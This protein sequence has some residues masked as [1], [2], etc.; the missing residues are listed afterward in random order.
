MDM[1]LGGADFIWQADAQRGFS[2]VETGVDLTIQTKPYSVADE[3]G[4]L[5]LRRIR[6]IGYVQTT[7]QLY[8]TPIVDGR[9]RGEAQTF[10]TAQGT[11]GSS[12]QRFER[13]LY[14]AWLDGTYG[15]RRPLRG[16]EFALQ[17]KITD[18]G[19]AF[20]LDAATMEF[21]QIGVRRRKEGV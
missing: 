10:I 12:F 11:G 13:L 6:V 7:F 16:T 9:L 21:R 2:G 8:V 4:E 20:H 19:G 1:V 15:V 5:V 14:P 3:H 18:P 17:L